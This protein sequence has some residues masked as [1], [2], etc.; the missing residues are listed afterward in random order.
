[1]S[2]NDFWQ[3]TSTFNKLH[4][5]LLNLLTRTIAIGSTQND[6]RNYAQLS[7]ENIFILH[8]FFLT[9]KMRQSFGQV[10]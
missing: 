9:I 7:N 5:V 3:S 8:V 2:Y 4:F 1:M 10:F 6:N